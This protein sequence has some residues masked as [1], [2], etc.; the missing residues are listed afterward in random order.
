[1]GLFA[2]EIMVTRDGRATGMATRPREA[3][4]VARSDVEMPAKIERDGPRSLC[5]ISDLSTAGARLITYGPLEKHALIM[6]TL[7]GQAGR[8]ARVVWANEFEAGCA[9]DEP[10]DDQAL[11]ALVSRYGFSPS[12]PEVAIFR[13]TS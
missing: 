9:F 8:L 10:L 12:L 6:L 3:R 13:G 1:M 7:P 2:A 5:R 11:K 4:R